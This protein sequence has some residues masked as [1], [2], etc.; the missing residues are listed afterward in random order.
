MLM[1]SYQFNLTNNLGWHHLK[2]IM[3]LTYQLIKNNLSVCTIKNIKQG[4]YVSIF[5]MFTK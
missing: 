5:F 4:Q 1:F 3:H 2:L